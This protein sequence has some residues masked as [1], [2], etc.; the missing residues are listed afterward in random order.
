MV[1]RRK[2]GG[3]TLIELLVSM[4]LSTVGLLGLLALQTIAIRGNIMSRNFT[5]AMGIAQQ[6]LETVQMTPYNSITALLG[7]EAC[8]VPATSIYCGTTTTG[9]APDGVAG[10]TQ[11]VYSRCTNVTVDAVNNVTTV[12]VRTCWQDNT[13]TTITNTNNWH[14]VEINA[15]RSP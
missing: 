3:F 11:A 10:S 4:A 2:S 7:T 12:L 1:A 13:N 9:L 6:R 15:E 14:K 8:P 5:E